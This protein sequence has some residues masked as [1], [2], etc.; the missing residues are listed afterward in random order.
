MNGYGVARGLWRLVAALIGATFLGFVLILMPSG[1]L[2]A[3]GLIGRGDAL[4]TG[5]SGTRTESDVPADASPL[6]GTFIDPSKPSLQVFDLSKLGGPPTGQLVD[7]P[8]KLKVKAADIGQVFGVALDNTPSTGPPDIYAA[9]TSL[10]GL[11][12]VESAGDGKLL[13]LVK[14]SPGARWMP[15][16]FGLDNGGGPGSIWKID[17]ATGASSLF[18]TIISGNTENAGPGLGGLA[19]D[20]VSRQLF[21]TNLETGLIHRIGPTGRDL[22]TFDQ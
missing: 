9:A 19:F 20:P 17:G 7:A 5:F 1:P 13:R 22:G 2:E 8:A 18:S 3:E 12:I 6:D 10:Y 21:V 16:Q 4:V 14:G 15:G 11:Q